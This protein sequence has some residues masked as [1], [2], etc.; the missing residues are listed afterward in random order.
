MMNQDKPLQLFLRDGAT[1]VAPQKESKIGNVRRWEQAFRVYAAIYSAANP[2]RAAEI[3]QYVY[4]INTAA[5]LFVW[6]ECLFL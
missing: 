6:G 5:A 4:I 1:F 2:S 3:W